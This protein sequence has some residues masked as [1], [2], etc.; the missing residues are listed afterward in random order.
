MGRLHARALPIDLLPRIGEVALNV[1]DVA[2]GHY[3][4]ATAAAPL[5]TV[6]DIVLDLE[7]P[8][9]VVL[10]GLQD[11]AGGGGRVAP[12]FQFE[13]VKERPVWHVVGRV[14]FR[15]NRVTRLEVHAAVGAGTNRLEVG[16]RLAGLRAFVGFKEMLGD[17]GAPAAERVRPEGRGLGEVDLHAVGVE[18]LDLFDL[19]VGADARGGGGGV[20][21]ELPIEDQV[22]GGERLAIVPGHALL[23]SPNHRAPVLADAAVPLARNLVSQDWHQVAVRVEGGERLVE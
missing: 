17:D 2:A 23:E 8:R 13:G 6:E 12:A 9:V 11:G 16:G 14:Q 5:E 20:G 22:V 21:G 18:F 10:P 7:I 19:A 4:H 1:L 3:V 15:T